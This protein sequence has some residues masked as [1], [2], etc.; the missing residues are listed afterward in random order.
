[1][2]NQ[3]TDKFATTGIGQRMKYNA[4]NIWRLWWRIITVRRL[5]WVSQLCITIILTAIIRILFWMFNIDVSLGAQ[6]PLTIALLLVNAVIAQILVSFV[7][8]ARLGELL[9]TLLEVEKQAKPP[10]RGVLRAFML[11]DIK[12]LRDTLMG[13]LSKDGRMMDTQTAQFWTRTC[14]EAAE[15]PYDGTDS[16]VPSEFLDLYKGYL[17]SHDV[18]L[19]K[20]KVSGTRILITTKQDLYDDYIKDTSNSHPFKDFWNWHD[21]T[22]NGQ[23]VSLLYIDPSRAKEMMLRY[24]LYTTDIGIWRDSFVLLFNPTK[25]GIGFR[26]VLKGDELYNSAVEF[27]SSLKKEALPIMYPP[28]IFEPELADKWHD[29]VEPVARLAQEG[30]FLKDTLKI[31]ETSISEYRNIF[32]AAAGIG[33][34][35][36]FLQQ[37][38]SFVQPNEIDEHLRKNALKYAKT[39]GTNISLQFTT[40]DWRKL[41]HYDGPKYDAVLVLGNSLCLVSKPEDRIKS[42]KGFAQMLRAGGILIIDERNFPRILKL[43]EVILDNPVKSFPFK[44]IMYCGTSV[45]GCPTHID[46]NKIIFVYYA[47]HSVADWDTLKKPGVICGTLEMYPFKQNELKELLLQYGFNNIRQFSDFNSKFDPNADFYT[48]IA[49]KK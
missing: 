25:D 2:V 7:I 6:V 35:S 14:F 31:S 18:N 13:V 36:V 10:A 24:K 46:E 28:D 21:Q 39:Q 8:L 43:K 44:G 23:K 22:R 42:V 3:D 11:N 47:N 29:F 9:E 49:V 38:G 34:E 27:F 48:Y 26:M 40:Y 17:E 30:N 1:M 19:K 15:T 20:T 5:P 37:N 41:V 16:H 4:R 32:D 45:R 33:V 12:G